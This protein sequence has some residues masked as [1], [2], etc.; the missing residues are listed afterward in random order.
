MISVPSMLFA[1]HLSGSSMVALCLGSVQALQLHA[2]S[3]MGACHKNTVSLGSGSGLGFQASATIPWL[4]G[5]GHPASSALL[6]LT[7]ACSQGANCV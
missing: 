2:G 6:G 5:L 3:H 4:G 1:L 7:W